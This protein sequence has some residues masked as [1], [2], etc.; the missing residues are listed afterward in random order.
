MDYNDPVVK[1]Y[2]GYAYIGFNPIFCETLEDKIL[3]KEHEAEMRRIQEEEERKAKEKSSFKSSFFSMFSG[4][5][6]PFNASVIN[7]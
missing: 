3:R 1:E 7:E 5:G 6:N 2:L 4:L